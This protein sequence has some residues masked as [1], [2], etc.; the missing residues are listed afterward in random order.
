MLNQMPDWIGIMDD[1]TECPC[2]AGSGK[3]GR[4]LMDVALDCPAC[5]GSGKIKND[6]FWIR[7][8]SSVFGVPDGIQLE[9]EL[10]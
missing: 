9:M 2:C 6:P 5:L 8:Y 7:Y 3:T 4:V 1:K 10:I